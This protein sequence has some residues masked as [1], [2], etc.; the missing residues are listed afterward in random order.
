MSGSSCQP[1][2]VTDF[3]VIL[4]NINSL[5]KSWRLWTAPKVLC[6]IYFFK[7]KNDWQVCKTLRDP[8]VRLHEIEVSLFSAFRPMLAERAVLEKVDTQMDHKTYYAET[9]YDGERSQIHKNKN[10]Y[11]YFSR[12]V[13]VPLLKIY[14][15]IFFIHLFIISLSLLICLNFYSTSKG[16]IITR[17]TKVK[18]VDLIYS[19][20]V[21]RFISYQLLKKW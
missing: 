14:L 6:A 12:Y 16:F 13:V 1:L 3:L 18:K 15:F 20:I 11:K 8:T 10:A 9:K 2:L 4:V 21:Y 7:T 5:W 19:C 17:N